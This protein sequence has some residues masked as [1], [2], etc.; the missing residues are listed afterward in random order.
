MLWKGFCVYPLDVV[1]SSSCFAIIDVQ[2]HSGD[3]TLATETSPHDITFLCRVA[4]S[5]RWS[6]QCTTHIPFLKPRKEADISYRRRSLAP[7][8]FL[9][10]PLCIFGVCDRV[11]DSPLVSEDLTVV[12]ALRVYE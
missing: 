3:H 9:E 7:G 8:Q 2:D 11:S 1:L 12:T 10:Y 4:R 5:R 6:V